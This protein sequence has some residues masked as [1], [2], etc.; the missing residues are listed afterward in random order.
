M[1]SVRLLHSDGLTTLSSDTDEFDV[2]N[3]TNTAITI[4]INEN[5]V[6]VGKWDVEV[7]NVL[8]CVDVLA[9]G[10]HVH[11]TLIVA[12]AAPPV[13]YSGINIQVTVYS[14]CLLY[15]SPSPRD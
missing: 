10:L 14:T 1:A 3:V 12:F 5:K 11:P 8:G 4:R 6:R 2:L 7:T 9:D 13:L 15:T